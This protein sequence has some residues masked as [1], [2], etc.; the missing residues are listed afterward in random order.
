MTGVV[1]A[2]RAWSRSLRF[3]RTI[4]VLMLAGALSGCA[5]NL[6]GFD[7]P[8]FGLTKKDKDAVSAAPPD[9]QPTSRLGEP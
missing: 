1:G 3:C 6:T 2:A 8:M 5:M 9:Q 4:A 7:F